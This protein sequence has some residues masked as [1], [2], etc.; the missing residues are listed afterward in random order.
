ML[1]LRTIRWCLVLCSICICAAAQDTPPSQP[2]SPAPA[3]GQNAPILN[4]ENPPLS[5]LDEP[6]LEL[7]AMTRSFI[8]P[9][10]QVGES[11]NS[12]V[13]NQLNGSSSGAVSHLIG[14]LDLQKLWPRSDLVLEYL[15]GAGFGDSPFYVRQLQAVGLEAVTRWR[16]GQVT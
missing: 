12:N 3:F 10:V 7:K 9:A 14:A 1:R 5:G 8:S 16:T 13:L 6:N 15:G 2:T 4:P 11:V